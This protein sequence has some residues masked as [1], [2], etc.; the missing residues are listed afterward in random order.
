MLNLIRLRPQASYA[1]GR[2][3]T[4]AEAYAV[5][6]RES[7]PVI[8]RLGARIIW[9][10]KLEQILIGP[11]NEAWD[12]CFIAEYPSVSAF[13]DMMRDPVYRA[14]MAHR[15]AATLDSRLVRLVPQALGDGFD[16]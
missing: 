5:Y 13:V 9:R 11:S 2:A 7:A 14:A 15:Q 8:A 1:D 6:G 10:G 3:A 16:G 4:G 12:I